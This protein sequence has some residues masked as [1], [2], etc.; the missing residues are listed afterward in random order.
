[1]HAEGPGYK[2][3]LKKKKPKQ[4]SC[5]LRWADFYSEVLLLSAWTNQSAEFYTGRMC[6]CLPVK[7]FVWN[8]NIDIKALSTN[9]ARIVKI[10]K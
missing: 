4:I 1:M 9:K 8:W 2:P 3:G 6:F 10:L 5:V 7:C